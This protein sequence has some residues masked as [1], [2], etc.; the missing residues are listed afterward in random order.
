MATTKRSTKGRKRVA[1][2]KA[3]EREL[4]THSR[5]KTPVAKISKLMKRTIG[6]LRQR[7]LQMG[8]PLGH[9]R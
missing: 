8:L 6:A 3:H 2:T 4:R 1:W 7:A 9:R 5:A